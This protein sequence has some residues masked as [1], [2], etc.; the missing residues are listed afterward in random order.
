MARWWRPTGANYFDRVP[1]SV[2]LAALAEV[3]GPALAG[4]YSKAKKAELAQGCERIFSG[5]F[6]AEVEVKE[7][8]LAWVPEAMR[9]APPAVAET[10]PTTP[11]PSRMTTETLRQGES[12]AVV[13]P[14]EE[15][16]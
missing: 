6:I 4:R 14:I 7:A 8:A 11:R 12:R 5:D 9:F 10:E 15:A 13:K 2:T 1:K 3:G 16:A